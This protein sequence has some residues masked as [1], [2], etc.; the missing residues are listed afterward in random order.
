MTSNQAKRLSSSRQP[1]E[2][3]KVIFRQP[4]LA[5][6]SHPALDG[7]ERHAQLG[8]AKSKKKSP[9]ETWKPRL[10]RGWSDGPFLPRLVR[11]PDL[12]VGA[13]RKSIPGISSGLYLKS[14]RWGNVGC[15]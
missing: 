13:R 5:S 4:P 12:W 2:G 8:S 14:R 1:E 15:D 10:G 7:G 3:I 11:T 6:A 9:A